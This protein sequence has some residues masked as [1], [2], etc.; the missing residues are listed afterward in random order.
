M[1]ETSPTVADRLKAAIVSSG[2][3]G[4]SPFASG[5]VGTLGGVA[6]AAALWPLRDQ[7]WFHFGG[8]MVVLTIIAIAV[9]VL[10]GPWA[11]RH[12]QRKDPGAFV[13]DEL[14]GYWVTLIRFDDGFPGW[15]EF[16]AAFFVFRVFDVIKPPP[17]RRIERLPHGWGIM[18]DDIIAG[19]YSWM[20]VSVL[21]SYLGWP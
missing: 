20:F 11:E 8:A 15:R 5:T 9:G 13:L 1:T 3:L 6:I 7:P 10:V 14:A 2:G 16:V 17:A 18:L 21:R 4:Y 12:Y 19:V